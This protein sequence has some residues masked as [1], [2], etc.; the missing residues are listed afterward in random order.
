MKLSL[1]NWVVL[2]ILY[3]ANSQGFAQLDSKCKCIQIPMEFPFKRGTN[4]MSQFLS[5]LFS[6]PSKLTAG[7]KKSP[8]QKVKS[9]SEPL[10][11][12]FMLLLTD[13]NLPETNTLTPV[14]KINAWKTIRLSFGAR[15]SFLNP[16]SPPPPPV[17]HSS[18]VR[19]RHTGTRT[20]TFKK[21]TLSPG[22]HDVDTGCI[23]EK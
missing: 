12:G 9:S 23:L 22:P 20:S 11:L 18:M 2:Y 4:E 5:V 13:G 21:G 10:F 19:V 14:K 8:L 7:I 17:T 1:Y 15:K 16:T 3:T 6:N